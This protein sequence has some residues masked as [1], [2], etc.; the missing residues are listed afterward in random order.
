MIKLTFLLMLM[1]SWIYTLIINYIYYRKYRNELASV[2][3]L[4]VDHSIIRF[5]DYYFYEQL[6]VK[7]FGYRVSIISMILKGKRIPID[8]K[9]WIEPEAGDLIR[10]HYDLSWI[11]GFYRNGYFMGLGFGVGLIYALLV[12]IGFLS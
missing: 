5:E 4:L 3:Q 2:F 6:G 8:N 11:R 1:F 12:K 7:G 10:K 9:R